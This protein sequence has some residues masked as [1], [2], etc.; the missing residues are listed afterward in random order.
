MGSNTSLFPPRPR[1][2][3][4]RRPLLAL[5][6]L[7]HCLDTTVRGRSVARAGHLGSKPRELSFPVLSEDILC[8]WLKGKAKS[9]YFLVEEAVETNTQSSLKSKSSGLFL[10][11]LHAVEVSA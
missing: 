2:T 7:S 9:Y 3:F 4:K 1:G 11:S 6:P 8:W 5:S 10:V